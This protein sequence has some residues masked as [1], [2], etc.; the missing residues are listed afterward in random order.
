MSHSETYFAY[1]GIVQQSSRTGKFRRIHGSFVRFTLH[2]KSFFCPRLSLTVSSSTRN[3]CLGTQHQITLPPYATLSLTFCPRAATLA[4]CSLFPRTNQATN[5]IRQH[6][7]QPTTYL[8]E[9]RAP[10]YSTG[11]RLPSCQHLEYAGQQHQPHS[12][13]HAREASPIRLRSPTRIFRTRHPLP[14]LSP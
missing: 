4:S 7:R 8:L 12:L 1:H 14:K 5:S 2:Y 11:F 9:N 10:Q 13:L 6:Q 3:C